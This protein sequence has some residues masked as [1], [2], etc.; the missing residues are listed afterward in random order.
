MNLRIEKE[1]QTMG[2]EWVDN[3]YD[4]IY[5]V[6]LRMVANEE[7]AKDLTQEVFLRAWEKRRSFR[8]D[9]NVGTWLYRIAVNI[10]LT[11]I[12]K[13]KRYSTLE[14]EESLIPA[15]G[16][17]IQRKT[18]QKGESGIIKEAILKLPPTYRMALI[19]HYYDGMKLSEIASVSGIS[20]GTAAWRL[21]KARKMIAG[22]LR[23]E[24]LNT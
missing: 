9:S 22:N 21:F 10:T 16:E 5:P 18:E 13:N 12:A 24:G 15:R 14:I 4:R 23:A 17:G 19:M 2:S 1:S 11:Y 20:R 7:I 8:G 3:Y 6:I